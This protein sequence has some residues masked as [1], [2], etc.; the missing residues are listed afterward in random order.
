MSYLK[1][2]QQNGNEE[3]TQKRRANDLK[4]A[5]T[6]PN[7]YQDLT[8]IKTKWMQSCSTFHI[9]VYIFFFIICSGIRYQINKIISLSPGHENCTFH[10]DLELDH[11]PPTRE[12]LL[13]DMAASYRLLLTGKHF[14]NKV[15]VKSLMNSFI[16][17]FASE[18]IGR[19]KGLF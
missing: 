5:R 8:I 7:H 10:H 2:K 13:P 12:A 16:H 6:D 19:S 3:P 9:I 4:I 17:A 14:L 15:K 18:R 11:R 1:T